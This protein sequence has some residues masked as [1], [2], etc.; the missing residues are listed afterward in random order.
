MGK[1]THHP[2]TPSPFHA[3]GV[4]GAVPPGQTGGNVTG[5]SIC[6]I[7][8]AYWVEPGS[9]VVAADQMT[10]E[11]VLVSQPPPNVRF[12]PVSTI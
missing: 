8:S 6:F 12:T 2:I 4:A 9:S 1:F 5:W 3:T 7:N 11:Q 10:V